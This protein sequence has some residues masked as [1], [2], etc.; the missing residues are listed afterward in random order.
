[1]V[2][3]A[4]LRGQILNMYTTPA[5]RRRGIAS[6]LVRLLIRHARDKQCGRIT[7]HALPGA[8]RIYEGLG[9]IG[10]DSEMKLELN[11]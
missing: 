6:E 1:M 10:T 3:L 8:R 11:T 2:S 9:F 4:G 5:W 7:L